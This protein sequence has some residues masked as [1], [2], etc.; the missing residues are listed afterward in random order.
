MK[1]YLNL[2]GLAY[3]F[4]KLSNKFA[5]IDSMNNKV[6]KVSG[7]GLS[8]NDYTT[9]EK[10]KLASLQSETW[11]FTLDDGSTVTKNVVIKS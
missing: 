1:D 3:F 2:N 6:D 8:T 10:T 7:K 4:N 11:T 5:T 9:T